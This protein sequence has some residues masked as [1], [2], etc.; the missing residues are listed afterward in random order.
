MVIV[1]TLH[2]ARPG[3]CSIERNQIHILFC[4]GVGGRGNAAQGV[5]VSV[6]T[7][8]AEPAGRTGMKALES[9]AM[10]RKSYDFFSRQ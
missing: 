9:S 7:R 2:R 5:L 10:Y 8:G 1:L 4:Y 3:T 6:K